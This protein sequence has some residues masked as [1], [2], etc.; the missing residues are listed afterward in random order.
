VAF[1]RA[2]GEAA[3][4]ARTITRESGD[5]PRISKLVDLPGGTLIVTA[6][7][8]PYCDEDDVSESLK[9]SSPLRKAIAGHGA[10][11][12][13]DLLV[14]D[15]ELE[16]A[17]QKLAAELCDE[18]ALVVQ[19]RLP[20]RGFSQPVLADDAARG[21]LAAGT[22]LTADGD[23]RDSLYLYE[24][25][26][27]EAEPQPWPARRKE[28]R[29]LADQ[30]RVEN[31]AGHARVRVRLS[32]GHAEEDLWLNVVR[33]KRAPY[34]SEELYGEVT[35]PSQLWPHLAP[36]ERIRIGF[37]EPLEVRPAAEE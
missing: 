21:Q 9:E 3:A 15:P 37:Y 29:E 34:R 30:A 16:L 17:A 6:R 7:A 13:I 20:R 31:P 33:S 5:A 14:A 23:D 11:I 10:W 26:A 4:K 32:R 25:E 22:F 8:A 36:G 28:L 2:A 27:E 12:A 35:E 18:Q 24:A 19:G 1:D